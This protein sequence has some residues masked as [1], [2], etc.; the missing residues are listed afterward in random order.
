MSKFETNPCMGC[1]HPCCIGFKINT[2]IT[3][4]TGTRKMLNQFS[5]INRVNSDVARH[6][7]GKIVVVGVYNCDMYDKETG[8][9]T[10]Y[11]TGKRPQFCRNTGEYIYPHDECR[12]KLISPDSIRLE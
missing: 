2:E 10:I 8:K 12:L 3:D 11:G 1:P 9:C 4:P 6:P 7:S 5:F